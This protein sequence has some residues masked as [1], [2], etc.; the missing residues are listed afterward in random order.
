MRCRVRGYPDVYIKI[1]Y[2][3]DEFWNAYLYTAAPYRKGQLVQRA[4]RDRHGVIRG[5]EPLGYYRARA[6]VIGL[7]SVL[8]NVLTELEAADHDLRALS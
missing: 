6:D 5:Y 1:G 7:A 2:S 3:F 4:V 8:S